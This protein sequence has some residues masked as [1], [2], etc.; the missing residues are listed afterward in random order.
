VSNRTKSYEATQEMLQHGILSGEKRKTR[1]R[2]KETK[3][4]QPRSKRSKSSKKIKHG[5]KS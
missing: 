4:K 3:R 2:R 1:V 5:G